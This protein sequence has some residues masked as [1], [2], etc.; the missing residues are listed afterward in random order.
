[1]T[2]YAARTNI[3]RTLLETAGGKALLAAMPEAQ[4]NSYLRRRHA[5]KRTSSSSSSRSTTRSGNTGIARN[6][7]RGGVR[8][9]V[10]TTIENQAGEVVAEVTLVGPSDRRTRSRGRTQ[11]GVAGAR[12]VVA[13]TKASG[14]ENHSER[15]RRVDARTTLAPTHGL[16]QVARSAPRL[17]NLSPSTTLMHGSRSSTAA[18]ASSDTTASFPLT[19]EHG[20]PIQL[21]L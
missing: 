11:R 4:R 14:P 9:A 13:T 3:R 15:L 2:G 6:T 17:L 7:V 21:R 18:A 16:G 12:G 5:M 1:M 19:P 10:A 8:S 20:E